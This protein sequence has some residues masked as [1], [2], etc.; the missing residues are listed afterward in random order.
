[1][2]R[3]I[4]DAELDDADG[5]TL[6]YNDAVERGTAIWND[7]PVGTENRRV[8]LAERRAAGLPVLVAVRSAAIGPGGLDPETAP[9]RGVEEVLGYATYGPFRPQDGFRYTVEHS[10]YIRAAHRGTGLGTD[11]MN[12]LI[13][14]ARRSGVHVMVAAV[15][16]ANPGSIRLHE[17]LGFTR[18]GILP[19]VGTKFGS[20]LDLALLQLILDD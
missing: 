17:S 9:D 16:A 3:H 12:A 19:E 6:I 2:N 8:W 15:D 10:V 1:M 7:H 13:A 4:R 14:R 5:I 18:C 20:W 11:L